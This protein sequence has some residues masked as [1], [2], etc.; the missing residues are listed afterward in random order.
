VSLRI[1]FLCGSVEA[2][3][4]IAIIGVDDSLA[5]DTAG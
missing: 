2:D 1:A 3:A 4:L 5:S